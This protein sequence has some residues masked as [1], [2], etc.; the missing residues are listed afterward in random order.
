MR[1]DKKARG[2]VIRFVIV[3]EPGLVTR[4]EAPDEALLKLAYEKVLP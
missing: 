1:I 2:D 3:K 4:L